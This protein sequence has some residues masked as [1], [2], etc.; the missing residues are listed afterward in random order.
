METLLLTLLGLS[1]LST[2][3]GALRIFFLMRA[4][5]YR[6]AVFK[7]RLAGR[8]AERRNE[9]RRGDWRMERA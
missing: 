9:N 6:R 4:Y 8:R 7:H 2:L 5:N 1:L 3:Y